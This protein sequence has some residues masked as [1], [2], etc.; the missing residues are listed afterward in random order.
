MLIRN[1]GIGNLRPIDCRGQDGDKIIQDQLK[2]L[3]KFREPLL[4][5]EQKTERQ[6]LLKKKRYKDF[7][8]GMPVFL[9]ITSKSM[10]DKETTP[11]V[12]C[13]QRT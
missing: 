4:P 3:G 10:I 2:R 11:K 6:K 8:L 9:D 13:T 1:P 12:C 5:S 7:Q